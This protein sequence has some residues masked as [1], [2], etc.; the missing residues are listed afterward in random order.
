MSEDQADPAHVPLDVKPYYRSA[1]VELA[2]SLIDAISTSQYTRNIPSGQDGRRF[3]ASVLFA[4]QCGLGVSLQRLL[5]GSPTYKK[6]GHW[7]SA[8]ALALCRSI[9]EAH[10]AMFYL[11]TDEMSDDDYQLRIRLVFLHDAQ[12]RPRIVDKI[13]SKAPGVVEKE[14]YA[15]ETARLRSEIAKNGVF[16][17]LPESK[18]KDLLRGKTPYYLTQDELLQRQGADASVLRGI[19][20]LLSSHVHSYP[21]SFYRVLQHKDRGTGRE[22]D[23]DKAYCGVAAQLSASM[24]ERSSEDMK[25]LFPEIMVRRCAIEWDSVT[26]HL[27]PEDTGFVYGMA[28]PIPA[29]PLASGVGRLDIDG[30]IAGHSLLS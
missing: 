28:T 5:P 21:F 29:S 30:S 15:S 13:S 6:G 27:L 3:W 14:F 12:E 17:S 24:L 1:L 19:W 20:E 7:D 16:L 23:V 22:N 9:F 26:C 10:L 18:Q 2:Q 8:G 11:C 25:A 4:R